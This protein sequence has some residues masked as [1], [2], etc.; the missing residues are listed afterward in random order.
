[1]L[2]PL[3]LSE[4]EWED[5]LLEY[6]KNKIRKSL[7]KKKKDYWVQRYYRKKQKEIELSQVT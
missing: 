7:I 5:L 3:S 1:M 6:Y 2:I 4:R